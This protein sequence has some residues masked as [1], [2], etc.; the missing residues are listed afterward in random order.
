LRKRTWSAPRFG[1]NEPGKAT[2]SLKLLIADSHVGHFD[3]IKGFHCRKVGV[4]LEDLRYIV[5]L[6]SQGEKVNYPADKK[7][8]P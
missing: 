2:C 7:S 4:V 1:F 6:S 5:Y 8:Q 3:A